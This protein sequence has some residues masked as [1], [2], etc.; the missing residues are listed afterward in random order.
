MYVAA[1]KEILKL[2]QLEKITVLTTK[3]VM[4]AIKM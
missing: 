4:L 3:I 2:T 1:K